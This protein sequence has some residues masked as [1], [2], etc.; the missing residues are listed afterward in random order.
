[1]PPRAD[2]LPGTLL[3]NVADEMKKSQDDERLPLPPEQPG[4]RGEELLPPGLGLGPIRQRQ[5]GGQKL[6]LAAGEPGQ[7]RFEKNR[8]RGR[9]L[10]N[11]LQRPV[12]LRVVHEPGRE[13]ELHAHVLVGVLGER[14]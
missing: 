7:K 3:G 5:A 8:V 10:E 4:I 13:G 6:G 11:G 14:R 12:R 2:L 9:F 1:M